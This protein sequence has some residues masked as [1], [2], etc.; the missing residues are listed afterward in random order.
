M[1]GE[2]F[3]VRP[4]M[5][6]GYADQ[7]ARQVEYLH[8]MR[9][10]LANHGK[11]S[12][13]LAGLLQAFVGPCLSAADWQIGVLDDMHRKLNDSVAAL[14][15]AAADYQAIDAKN[16]GDLDKSYPD[17]SHPRRSR[18]GQEYE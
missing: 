3:A 4:E 12:E 14:R 17:G 2:G 16:A 5:L 11:E 15:A 7:L 6:L 8:R 13:G 18:P 10:H 1:A 9:V